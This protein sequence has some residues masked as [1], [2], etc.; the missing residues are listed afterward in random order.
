MYS[1][2]I[3][4]SLGFIA[5]LLISRMLARRVEKHLG[6]RLGAV[7]HLPVAVVGAY[8]WIDV[9]LH[10]PSLFDDP[11]FY[12]WFFI[13]ISQTALYCTKRRVRVALPAD[14][15]ILFFARR[16]MQKHRGE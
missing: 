10:R 5:V 11:F 4:L 7:V 3:V 6:S 15:S 2:L 12:F 14:K 9:M 16:R 1:T 13:I 8:Y